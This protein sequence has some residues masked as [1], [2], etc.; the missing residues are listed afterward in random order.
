MHAISTSRR[1]LMSSVS[2]CSSFFLVSARRHAAS[3]S[4]CLI[5]AA[6]LAVDRRDRT[7][8]AVGERAIDE[9]AAAS[10]RRAWRI[11]ASAEVAVA[12]RSAPSVTIIGRAAP[13]I[14]RA[15]MS[16]PVP[17]AAALRGALTDAFAVDGDCGGSSNTRGGI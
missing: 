11:A 4:A 9:R 14:A 13:L 15:G 3:Y 6:A 17:A 10:A 2:N 12:G 8:L 1:F 5:R 16:I 7:V